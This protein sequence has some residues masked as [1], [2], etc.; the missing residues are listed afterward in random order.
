MKQRMRIV[1]AAAVAGGVA[2]GCESLTDPHGVVRIVETRTISAEEIADSLDETLPFTVQ[3]GDEWTFQGAFDEPP[4]TS[5]FPIERL[6]SVAAQLRFETSL[7]IGAL[8]DVTMSSGNQTCVL[9]RNLHAGE[10]GAAPVHWSAVCTDIFFSPDRLLSVEVLATNEE[11]V[12]VEEDDS[13]TVS[14]RAV[15]NFK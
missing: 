15:L 13:V 7:D 1:L 6:Q 9:A 2:S 8:V 4:Q 3:S 12:T 11:A 14:L 5:E 10:N